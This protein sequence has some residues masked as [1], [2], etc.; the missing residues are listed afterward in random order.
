MAPLSGSEG[1]VNRLLAKQD[2]ILTHR[3]RLISTVPEY[4]GR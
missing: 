1:G 4:L 2:K 3:Q